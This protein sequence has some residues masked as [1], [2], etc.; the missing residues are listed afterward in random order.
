MGSALATVS[1]IAARLD[2]IDTVLAAICRST[3]AGNQTTV[4]CVAQMKH[5]PPER[6][7]C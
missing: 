6:V 1:L 2:L 4:K 3:Y 5:Q 7:R